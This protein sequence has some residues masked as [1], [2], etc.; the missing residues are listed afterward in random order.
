MYIEGLNNLMENILEDI[1]E[2]LTSH[3]TSI[4]YMYIYI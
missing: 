4:N 3:F 1:S 2:R